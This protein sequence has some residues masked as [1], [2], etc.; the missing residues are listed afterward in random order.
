MTPQQ[1]RGKRKEAWKESFGIA[2]TLLHLVAFKVLLRAHLLANCAML[3]KTLQNKYELPA[4][5]Q[6]EGLQ[7]T[8]LPKG[9]NLRG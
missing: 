5:G 8:T 6:R 4:R 1:D 9:L 7:R 3:C 2:R